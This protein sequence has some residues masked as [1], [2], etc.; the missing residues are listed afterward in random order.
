[1]IKG[2][3]NIM[4][5]KPGETLLDPMMGSGTVLIEATLMG[6]NSIGIDASPF[7]E[8]MAKAKLVGL[9]VALKYVKAAVD[10]FDSTFN[11]FNEKIAKAGHSMVG[12]Q[13]SL[14]DQ[15]KTSG[16]DETFI[17]ERV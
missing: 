6:V 16:W 2:L 3:I 1:M 17:A 11:Y 10:D 14:F 13:S 8:F 7:C 15:S 5:L 4:G 9:K 12:A